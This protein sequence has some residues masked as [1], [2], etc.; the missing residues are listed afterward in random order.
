MK[1]PDNRPDPPWYASVAYNTASHP[2]FP[3]PNLPQ[4]K[5]KRA[6]HIRP[7]PSAALRLPSTASFPSRRNRKIPSPITRNG[8][9]AVRASKFPK[10]HPM[11]IPSLTRSSRLCYPT[12][13]CVQPLYLLR[14]N[15]ASLWTEQTN[16][17]S[18]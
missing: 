9:Y 2:A 13:H 11:T 14:K 6:K 8:S 10:A 5:A 1:I 3:S 17:R 7:H 16:C 12:P 18:N 15:A 4:P